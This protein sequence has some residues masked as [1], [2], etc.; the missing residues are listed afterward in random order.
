MKLSTSTRPREEAKFMFR[1]CPPILFICLNTFEKGVEKH[2][3]KMFET[4]TESNI[5]QFLRFYFSLFSCFM[6]QCMYENSQAFLAVQLFAWDL[7][8]AWY[9]T[10]QAAPN[11]ST[12]LKRQQEWKGQHRGTLVLSSSYIKSHSPLKSTQ[13]IKVCKMTPAHRQFY[14]ELLVPNNNKYHSSVYSLD[15][16]FS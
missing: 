3:A 8:N 13:G 2:N 12:T 4:L 16:V 10:E 5:L 1:T 15:I 7:S 6:L 14:S 11:L 9:I